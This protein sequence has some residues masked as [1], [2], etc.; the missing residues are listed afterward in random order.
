MVGLEE[1]LPPAGPWNP[2]GMHAHGAQDS[3]EDR[4]RLIVR[5]QFHFSMQP[6]ARRFFDADLGFGWSLLR[7]SPA[8]GFLGQKPET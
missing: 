5:R 3:A 6:N 2:R 7:E 4:T 8:L 1:W